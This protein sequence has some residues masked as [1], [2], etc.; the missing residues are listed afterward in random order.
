MQITFLGTSGGTPTRGRNVSAFVLRLPERG[1]QWLFDCGEGTQHQILRTSHISLAR[2]TRIFI[3]HLHGDHLYGLPGLL[4]SRALA[5]SGGESDVV[6][7]YGPAGLDAYLRATL[8]VAGSRIAY[9]MEVV[10]VGGDGGVLHEDAD[11]VVRAAPVRHRIAAFAYSAEEK[12]RQGRFD[13]ERAKSLGVPFGPLYG[14]L[15]NGGSVTLD[16]GR[17]VDGAT[18]VGPP[19]R[20]RKLVYSGDTAFAPALVA[21]AQNADVLIH[22]ATYS[23]AERDLAARASHSTAANA[24][25]VAVRAD[26]TSLYLTHFSGRYDMG[27]A[28]TQDN[29]TGANGIESLLAEAQAIFPNTRLAH[30]FL[31]VDVSRR[32][33]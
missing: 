17:I 1:E 18:L 33:P 31:R 4:A 8:G 32:E 30:D 6:T 2:V 25:E 21:L 28:G 23:D 24:A 13:A 22:E 3:T 27:G 16:N 11:F 10:T 14:V 9:P 15:K 20:G 29:D 12:E 5:Q 26:V 19:R 7:I